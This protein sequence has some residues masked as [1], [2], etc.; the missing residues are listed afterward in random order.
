[1]ESFLSHFSEKTKSLFVVRIDK[2]GR[3]SYINKHYAHYFG[4]EKNLIIGS[5]SSN[6]IIEQDLPKLNEVVKFCFNNPGQIISTELTKIINSIEFS[7]NWEFMGVT[8]DNNCIIEILGV[9][10]DTTKRKKLEKD[11]KVSKDLMN[12]IF[13]QSFE[14]VFLMLFN[15]PL[16]LNENENLEHITETLYYKPVIKKVNKIFCDQYNAT[17]EQMLG[18]CL[19]DFFP[20]ETAG[21]ALMYQ[22]LKHENFAAETI[23]KTVTGEDIIIAGNYRVIKDDEGRI[24]G[25]FGVQRDVTLN[26]YHE[27]LLRE[28]EEKYRLIAEKTSD[29]IVIFDSENKISYC[30]PAY[31]K[32][33]GYSIIEEL[34]GNA[35]RIQQLIHP[36]DRDKVEQ[37]LQKAEQEKLSELFYSYRIL[38]KDNTYIWREDHAT[39]VYDSFKNLQR[40][41]VVCRD[42]TERKLKEEE[43]KRL[44][45]F[46]EQAGRLA[47]VGAFDIDLVNNTAYW[48][49]A[50]S[51]ILEIDGLLEKNL[52]EAVEL[53]T[54]GPDK[55]KISSTIAKALQTGEKYEVE[56]TLV[57]GKNNSRNVKVI[58]QPEMI[59]GFCYR[60]YGTITDITE[61]VQQKTNLKEITQRLEY[62]LDKMQDVVW[63]TALPDYKLIYITPSVEKLFETEAA[64]FYKDTNIWIENI[65]PGDKWVVAKINSDLETKGHYEYAYRM[66]LKNGKL[67]WVNNKGYLIRD[68]L[69]VPIRIDGVISDI[70]DK[71]AL[72]FQQKE[73]YDFLEIQNERLKQFAYTVSHNLRSHAG[74]INALISLTFTKE[75][76]T[77][78]SELP[79]ILKEASDN[80]LETINDLEDIVKVQSM[81]LSKLTSVNLTD[82]V[83][84]GLKNISA[85]ALEKE[86]NIIN[87]VSDNLFVVGL[88]AYLDSI[89]NNLFTNAI[90]YSDQQKNNKYIKIYTH[91]T[92]TEACLTIEDNGLGIDMTR[93][94]ED[95]FKMG[96]TFHNKKGARGIGLYITKNQVESMGGRIEVESFPLRG[97]TFKVYLKLDQN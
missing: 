29:G 16:I 88:K 89:A 12:A 61:D 91:V 64:E 59:E 2:N 78:D 65:H 35:A 39:F 83:K 63:S 18:R 48:S 68:E 51:E 62:V 73:Y 19:S 7:A 80:L 3:F 82:I 67:K 15:E 56:F 42:I 31:L 32:Q 94:K 36:E 9:G 76:L 33:L 87:Q 92:E 95:L 24:I 38:R 75:G 79:E 25:H 81:E 66:L 1:M 13:E 77:K 41:Y 49:N 58:G 40:T 37:L 52:E 27:K 69:G 4:I 34:N 43:N 6:G 50:I 84:N 10:Y 96:R 44:K 11:Q 85:L 55:V 26:R 70:S 54:K 20:D 53:F 97:S 45:N 46:L 86:I 72:E 30:S 57:T 22:V 47:K 93:Y 23:E 14:G 90:K 71:K 17:E 8:D 5:L 21:K 60:L 74:N 28:S